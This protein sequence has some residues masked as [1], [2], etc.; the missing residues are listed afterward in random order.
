MLKKAVASRDWSLMAVREFGEVEVLSSCWLGRGGLYRDGGGGGGEL[1][2]AA[3]R[4]TARRIAT[5]SIAVKVSWNLPYPTLTMKWSRHLWVELRVQSG[6]LTSWV[7]VRPAFGLATASD[8]FTAFMAPALCSLNTTFHHRNTPTSPN[9]H[10]PLWHPITFQRSSFLCH[11]PKSP[12][13]L[14]INQFQ[15]IPT[16]TN[17]VHM[18]P[19]CSINEHVYEHCLF[20]P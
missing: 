2:C 20:G 17:H 12:P 7:K 6:H 11:Y 3:I 16:D 4:E 19:G 13:L 1:M 15:S 14:E 8:D 10:P 18:G 5:T 9:H